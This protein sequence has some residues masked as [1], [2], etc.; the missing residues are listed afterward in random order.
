MPRFGVLL[1]TMLA[2]ALALSCASGRAPATTSA[3]A[4]QDLAF[5]PNT[6]SFAKDQPARITFKNTAAQTHDFTVERMPVASVRT[7][8]GATAG[9]DMAKMDA[10]ALHLAL[11]G[12]KSGQI[13]FKPTTAGDYEFY[14]MVAGHREGGMRGTIHVQ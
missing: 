13:D 10:P 7:Q 2:A 6:L 3:M 9:H 12:G 8:G 4:M 1:V 5:A 11:D 14:C